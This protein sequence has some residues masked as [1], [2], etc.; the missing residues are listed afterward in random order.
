M[1]CYGF[2]LCSRIPTTYC[3]AVGGALSLYI[4]PVYTALDVKRK[5]PE[6]QTFTRYYFVGSRLPVAAKIHCSGQK[7]AS[8]RFLCSCAALI[9]ELDVYVCHGNVCVETIRHT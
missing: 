2:D 3:C 8:A 4:L 6:V 1:L 5:S 9:A 7:R